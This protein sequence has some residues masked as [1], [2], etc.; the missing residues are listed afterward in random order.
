M[1]N[2]LDWCIKKFISLDLW[3]KM[4]NQYLSLTIQRCGLECF[5]DWCLAIFM[6]TLW[7]LVAKILTYW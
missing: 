3:T 1:K 4:R 7:K 6:E 2:F 5:M